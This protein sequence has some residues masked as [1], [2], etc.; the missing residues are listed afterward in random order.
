LQLWWWLVWWLVLQL[1]LG[2]RLEQLRA[3]QQCQRIVLHWMAAQWL[4]QHDNI[5]VQILWPMSQELQQCATDQHLSAR[6]QLE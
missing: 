2:P 6:H 3:L 1:G 4:Q 5:S